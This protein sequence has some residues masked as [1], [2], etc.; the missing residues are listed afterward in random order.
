MASKELATTAFG[1]ADL[2]NCERE[3]IHL[4]GSIQPHGALLVVREPDLV[5]IQASANASTYLGIGAP[6]IG[7]ALSEIDGDL[8][9]SVR[10]YLDDLLWTIPAAVRCH[11]GSCAARFDGLLHRPPQGGLI[12]ELER[13]GPPVD[14]SGSVEKAL[15]AIVA[16]S[17]LRMLCDESA[18]RFK[19]I[20][21]YDRVMIYRFDEQGHGEVYSEVRNPSLESY[22]GNRYPDSDI[23]QIARRLY[24]RNRVRLL[25]D[26]GYAPVQLAPRLSPVTGQELDMSLC[27]LRSMSPIHIQ[28]L[29]NMGVAATLVASL[30]VGGKL[31]GLVACHHYSPRVVHYE[32]RAAC[33]VLAETIAARIAALESFVRAQAEISVRR[34]EQRMIE[35]ISRDGDWRNALFDNSQSLLQPLDAT[36]AAL[37]FEGQVLTA[38]EVPSTPQLRAVG[39]WLDLQPRA[40]IFV[41]ASLSL[42]ET[43][44]A[45]LKAVASG[46]LA[47]PV[48]ESQGEYLIWFRPERIRTVTWAGDPTKPVVIGDNPSDLSPR[49]SFAQWHQRVEGTSDPWTQSDLSAARLIGSTVTDVILQFRAVRL[50]IAQDQLEQVTR[51]VRVAQL[52]VAIADSGGRILLAND[53]LRRL[54]PAA[55]PPLERVEQLATY[56]VEHAEIGERLRELLNHWRTWRGEAHLAPTSSGAQ[57]LLVRFDPV[58]SSPDR[59]QGF[60]LLFTDVTEQKAADAAR[61]RFQEGIIERHRVKPTHLNSRADLVYRNLLATLMENAQ[62]AALE[63]TDGVDMARM[64]ELLESLRISVAR[65]A[66]VLERLVSHASR[67]AEDKP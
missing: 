32:V 49:R 44:F 65:S 30:V 24:E 47:T 46:L 15:H 61:R 53:A 41:T 25:V 51:Q 55:R 31:W 38:G 18:R 9:A 17:S 16:C 40:P 42:D 28:Y 60:V 19:D 21:G 12:I 22:L 67:D 45:D 59:V 63:I 57:P 33:E 7:R 11:V 26:V 66:E 6:L 58:F 4:A 48:S 1:R 13:A 29:K 10:P 8:A 43:N 3:Q 64:Q 50:L 52:P 5:V 35:A 27:F 23:P 54:L 14:L 56:F 20:T 37:L 39:A 2:S 34:L 36:G 62:L